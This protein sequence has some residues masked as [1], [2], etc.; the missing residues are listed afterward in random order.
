MRPLRPLPPPQPLQTC[1]RR[2]GYRPD[3]W[4]REALCASGTC[5]PPPPPP[6]PPPLLPLTPTPA[7]APSLAPYLQ[8]LALTAS[9]GL[10]EARDVACLA[11]TN[12]RLAA[13]CKAAPLRLGVPVRATG[14]PR[15]EQAEARATLRA[16]C[17][18]WP[19]VLVVM[20][21]SISLHLL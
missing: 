8:V 17:A 5:H 1:P 9:L 14:A 12:K 18:S 10:T 2:Y 21:T 13:V 15:E 16:L 3:A 7:Q 11:A 4:W 20:R 19:G 6:P